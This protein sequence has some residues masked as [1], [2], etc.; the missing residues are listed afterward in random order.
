[1]ITPP[2]YFPENCEASTSFKGPHNG[3]QRAKASAATIAAFLAPQGGAGPKARPGGD[4]LK[5][6]ALFYYILL[7]FLRGR[8]ALIIKELQALFAQ[9]CRLK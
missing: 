9:Q 8:Y 6:S 1:L 7:F 4:N 3:N 2:I 5:S